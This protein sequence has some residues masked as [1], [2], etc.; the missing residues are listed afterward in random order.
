MSQ[1][2]QPDELM[3]QPPLHARRIPNPPTHPDGDPVSV[4]GVGRTAASR[5]TPGAPG[6]LSVPT[7]QLSG[8][9]HGGGVAEGTGGG[10]ARAGSSSAEDTAQRNFAASALGFRPELPAGALPSDYV[11]EG[12]GDSSLS[13]EGVGLS[14]ADVLHR[15]TAEAVEKAEARH[16]AQ[17]L[18]NERLRWQLEDLQQRLAQPSALPHPSASSQ[19]LPTQAQLSVFDLTQRHLCAAMNGGQRPSGTPQGAYTA[20]DITILLQ[21]AAFFTPV[22]FDASVFDFT[23]SEPALHLPIHLSSELVQCIRAHRWGVGGVT[24]ASIRPT[25]AS[26]ATAVGGDAAMLE[27]IHQL[28]Q[29]QLLVTGNQAHVQAA[30]LQ[31]GK[32]PKETP[33]RD[34]RDLLD[35]LTAVVQLLRLLYPACLDPASGR[36]SVAHGYEMAR[37]AVTAVWQQWGGVS[38]AWAQ[39]IAGLVDMAAASCL[40]RIKVECTRAITLQS[41][42][43]SPGHLPHD[44]AGA[45]AQRAAVVRESF[46]RVLHLLT[47]T[48]TLLSSFA[49]PPALPPASP[50]PPAPP[51]THNPTP[52]PS[53]APPADTPAPAPSPAPRSLT[54]QRFIELLRPLK[55][56]LPVGEQEPCGK[57]FYKELCK[58][59][60]A[61]GCPNT[62]CPYAHTIS[63]AT[64]TRILM[65]LAAWAVRGGGRV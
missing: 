14:D 8:E 36:S 57:F 30:A 1:R 5:S 33:I 38:A 65:A 21:A 61:T 51:S 27:A 62:A 60:S 22:A 48:T 49:H 42:M 50:T 15:V 56:S 47:D 29:P 55:R 25:F 6:D 18:E 31:V 16:R 28:D 37:R 59:P 63:D 34:G 4:P 64:R 32:P 41:P 7:A 10:E 35:R 40:Y 43:G 53:P 12:D 13:D 11:G 39:A 54:Q 9:G 45:R 19:A 24:L 26:E 44:L 52:A 23:Q 46:Q 2:S 58:A 20:Q 3:S 17:L